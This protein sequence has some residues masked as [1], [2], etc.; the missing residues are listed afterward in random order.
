MWP[1]IYEV[2]PAAL[3]R[4]KLNLAISAYGGFRR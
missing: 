4:L 2:I 1:T 3:R